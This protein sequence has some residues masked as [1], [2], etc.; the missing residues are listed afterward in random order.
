[1]RNIQKMLT[2]NAVLNL[3]PE[4][5]KILGLSRNGTYQGA[6]EGR[7]PTIEGVGRLRKVPVAWLRRVLQIDEPAA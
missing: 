5:G 7:I 2:E 1:M 4:T 6:A 3:W